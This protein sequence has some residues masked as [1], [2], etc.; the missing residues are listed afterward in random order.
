MIMFCLIMTLWYVNLYTHTNIVVLAFIHS[1]IL[2][3]S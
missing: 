3:P 1:I 2:N